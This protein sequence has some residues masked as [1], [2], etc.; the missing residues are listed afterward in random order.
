MSTTAPLELIESPDPVLRQVAVPVL[1]FD[2]RLREI[3]NS[4]I[5]TLSA[6]GGIG[7][8]APQVGVSR[9]IVVTQSNAQAESA[10]V[11]INPVITE[12]S[13]P[14]LVQESCLSLPGVSGT[15][16]RATR[17]TVTAFSAAGESFTESLGGMEAVCIQHEIDHLQGILF[18]DRLFWLSRLR[19]KLSPRKRCWWRKHRK[20]SQSAA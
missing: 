12:R 17:L 1:E 4:L 18:I 14:G 19:I 6:S 2:A 10:K 13:N 8:S 3:T 7:L 16:Q 9:R 15:V 20:S 11:Y 5:A